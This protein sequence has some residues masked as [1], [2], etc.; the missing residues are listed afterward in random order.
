MKLKR[1]VQATAVT[2]RNIFEEWDIFYLSKNKVISLTK[3]RCKD[4]FKLLQEKVRTEP[5]TVKRWSRRFTNSDF[6][7]KQ[8]LHKIYITTSDK[9]LRESGYKVFHRI[10]VTNTELKLFKIGNDDLCFQCKNPDS[11]QHTFFE[12]YEYSILS[13]NPIV[14]QYFE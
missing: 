2:I 9:Q 7:W 11:L 1:R 10:L 5:I 4:F 3:S 12:S 13:R 6:S 14:V 8:I